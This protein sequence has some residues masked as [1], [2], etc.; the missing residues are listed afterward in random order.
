MRPGDA[1]ND[2]T[3]ALNP[4]TNLPAS[5]D[6]LES[7]G[8]SGAGDSHDPSKSSGLSESSDPSESRNLSDSRDLSDPSDPSDPSDRA[9][10]RA[11][12]AS[13][14]FASSADAADAPLLLSVDRLGVSLSG[15]A[16][17]RDV[18][19]SLAAGEVVALIGPNGGGKSTLLKSIVRQRVAGRSTVV[20]DI[21]WDG[22]PLKRWSGKALARRVAM[23]PQHPS[24]DE[25]DRVADVLRQGRSGRWGWFGLETPGDEA[26]VRRVA[27]LMQVD[28]LLERKIGTLSGG[29]RQRVFVGRCLV[30]EP[31]ALLLDEPG[32]FLDLRHQLDLHRLLHRLA[33]RERLGVLIASHDLNLAAMFADWMILLHDGVVRAAGPPG[34]VMQPAVLSAAYEVP[35]KR[36]TTDDGRVV[37]IPERDEAAGG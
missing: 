32:T 33:R 20:G 27:G 19:L 30:Q 5:R 12:T 36:L 34:E 8:P 4:R 24:C 28:D 22:R 26:V 15:R 13:S 17:L 35:L 23:L 16:V 37:V 25:T 1:S 11:S 21:R 31:A 29:Q 7:P 18:A 14:V 6:P 10:S 2:A 9:I 3:R